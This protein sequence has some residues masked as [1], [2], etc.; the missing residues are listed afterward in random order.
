[1]EYWWRTALSRFAV[2]VSNSTWFS[3]L[4][5]RDSCPSRLLL[6]SCYFPLY[7]DRLFYTYIS[8]A[9][10]TWY[11]CDWMIWFTIPPISK[12]KNARHNRLT[13]TAAPPT[14]YSSSSPTLQDW[15]IMKSRMNWLQYY[16]LS[17]DCCRITSSNLYHDHTHLKALSVQDNLN[18]TPHLKDS[19]LL[20]GY[21]VLTLIDPLQ[22]L[23]IIPRF[24]GSTLKVTSRIQAIPR[25]FKL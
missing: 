22:G 7:N 21:K 10:S 8:K 15:R 1:M 3:V 11:I 19:S 9:S 25:H 6:S 18:A 5:L 16:S 4:I 24:Q 13:T 2:V 14:I 12:M 20:Q 17:H 23:K